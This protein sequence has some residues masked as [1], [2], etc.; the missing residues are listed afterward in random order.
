MVIY[1]IHKPIVSGVITRVKKN[2]LKHI[3]RDYMKPKILLLLSQM[4][5][6]FEVMTTAGS[7]LVTH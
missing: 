6:D 5:S 2:H 3:G 4:S 7:P 1:V